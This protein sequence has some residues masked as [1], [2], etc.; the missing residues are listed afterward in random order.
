VFHIGFEGSAAIVDAKLQ[1]R[2]GGLSS[3]GLAEEGL[4][5]QAVCSALF[6]GSQEE[7]EQ[8]LLV[9]NQRTA[10]P[11]GSVE[12]LKRTFGSFG[13]PEGVTKIVVI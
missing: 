6:S 7:L 5:K 11:I 1:S 13:I 3:R 12:E 8:V 2:F 9:F 10:H 4:F